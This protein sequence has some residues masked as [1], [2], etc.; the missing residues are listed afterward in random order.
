MWGLAGDHNKEQN[1]AP[2]G[3]ADGSEWSLQEQIDVV[4]GDVSEALSHSE[5]VM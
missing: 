4:D 1:A 5:E 3:G 2:G